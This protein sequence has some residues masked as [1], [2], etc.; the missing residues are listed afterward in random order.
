MVE[1]PLVGWPSASIDLIEAEALPPNGKGDDPLATPFAYDGGGW[2]LSLRLARQTSALL[3]PPVP[4]RR[5]FSYLAG[6]TKRPPVGWS[7]CLLVEAAGVEPASA[8]TLPLALH[9]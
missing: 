2:S 3:R 5:G 9:A 7:F 8:S 1:N 4:Y 6:Q